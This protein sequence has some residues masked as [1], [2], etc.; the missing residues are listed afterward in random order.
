M[1]YAASMGYYTCAGTPSN[2][3][4]PTLEPMVA[5]AQSLT[6]P[7]RDAALQEIAAYVHDLHYIIPVGYP[8]SYFGLREGINWEPRMDGF[9][10]IKEFSVS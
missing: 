8:A 7:E 6:G 4:D 1:D 2:L 5:E 9:V 3:C 10:L